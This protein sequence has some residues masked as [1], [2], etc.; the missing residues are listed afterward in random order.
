MSLLLAIGTVTAQQQP[1]R[2]LNKNGKMD[3]YENVKLSPQKRVANLL[4]LMTIEEKA[5]QMF[6]T[7][8][9][10]EKNGEVSKQAY[11]TGGRS[12]DSLILKQQ[13]SHFNLVGDASARAI[14][15]YNNILQKLAEGTRL[16]I[17]I[18]LSTDPRNSYKQTD[19]STAVSAGDFSAFS[20]PVGFAAIRDTA[21]M[22][23]FA[24]LAAKEYRAV[25]ITMALHPMADLATEPRWGR[26]SGTF[27][28][29]AITASQL[30]SAYIT[31]FQG[32]SL[33]P[34]SVACITKHFPGGGPQK[35]GWESHFSYGRDYV[36]PGNNFKYHLLPFNAAIKAGTAG[37]MTGYGISKGQ[38]KEPVAASFNKALITDLLKQKMQ[39]KGIVISDWNTLTDKYMGAMKLIEA[40]SWGMDSV[41]VKEKLL[42]EIQAGVDQIG[43]ETQTALLSALI[44]DNEVPITLI[45]ASV[46][47]ILLLKFQLGLFDNPY[48]DEQAV[49][50]KVGLEENEKLGLEQ[51]QKSLVLLSNKNNFL[52]VTKGKKIYVEGYADKKY[53]SRYGELVDQIELCDFAIIHLKTPYG[54]PRTNSLMERYFHQGTLEFED[55]IKRSIVKKLRLKPT[56]VVINLERAA[57]I[58]E[59][60]QYTSAL[61]ADFGASEKAVFP[62]LF[63]EVKPS[64]KLP[65]EL[66]SSMKAVTE[67]KEDVPHDS[68]HPLFPYGFGL[69][70]K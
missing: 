27:G 30:L 50:T 17:P 59:I 34:Q 48:V 24:H 45:N 9:M 70:Y 5:G 6:H 44:K 57:V 68:Q 62:I 47:K 22:Y 1:Y 56:I 42:K 8:S 29:D 65:F 12:T 26:I 64:G 3:D 52:P 38:T 11:M 43:G 39:F 4:S 23:R 20:E 14:A 37:I 18:T 33:N 25:G 19:M 32:K 60:A 49:K 7:Y 36:Y 69:S 54:P 41:S 66:P 28:E 21:L 53:F 15:H 46:S 31:G 2:D 58:P 35:E 16:G 63:G 10:L 40:R 51:Q 61:L 13:M 55:S 67:Q